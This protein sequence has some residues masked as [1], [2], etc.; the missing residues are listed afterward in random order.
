MTM[1]ISIFGSLACAAEV[2]VIEALARGV[3]EGAC[4]GV[5]MGTV[6]VVAVILAIEAVALLWVIRR[7]RSRAGAEAPDDS[8]IRSAGSR[9]DAGPIR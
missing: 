9:H 8:P 6:S 2:S 3:P 7:A 1:D 4:V 5:G